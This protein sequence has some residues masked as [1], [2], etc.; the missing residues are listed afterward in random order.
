MVKK[1][2]SNN[3]MRPTTVGA[4]IL[5]SVGWVRG[6]PPCDLQ[7]FAKALH[8]MMACKRGHGCDLRCDIGTNNPFERGERCVQSAVVVTGDGCPTGPLEDGC[9]GC[10]L[11]SGRMGNSGASVHARGTAVTSIVSS[12]MPTPINGTTSAT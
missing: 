10:A 11:S 6:L 3:H 9:D 12:S 8:S 2:N 1:P 5:P 4:F 7:T